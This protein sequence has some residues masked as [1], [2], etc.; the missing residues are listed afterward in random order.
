M[1]IDVIDDILANSPQPP[2]IILQSD[3]GH[4]MQAEPGVAN[5]DVIDIYEY[6]FPIFNSYYLPEY[7]GEP[8]P[9]D[10]TPV[11]T[12]RLIFDYYFGTE[13]GLLEDR[14]FYPE[15]YF[16]YDFIEVTDGKIQEVPVAFNASE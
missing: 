16:S 5:W 4:R 14:Y 12:F 13:F 8:I 1:I 6:V 11:N 7:K 15:G 10:I 9:S 2:I 3:H